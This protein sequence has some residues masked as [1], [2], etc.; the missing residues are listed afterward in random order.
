[1]RRNINSTYTNLTIIA[2]IS[3]CISIFC[4]CSESKRNTESFVFSVMGD[5]PRSET[6]K[7]ILQEQ[8]RKHNKQSKSQ[9]V[10]HVGDIKSGQ[11]YCD[12]E[13]YKIVADYLKQFKVPVFI[14]PG[15]NEWNDCKNPNQAWDF[16]IKYFSRFDQ[17]WDVPFVVLRQ[18]NYPVNI[19]FVKNNILFIAINLVGG[20]IH[21]KVEWDIMQQN[22]VDWIED[23]TVNNNVNAAVILAQA[24]F[25]EKHKIF[26]GQ[27][28]KLVENFKKPIMF[29]HGDGHVWLHDDPWMLPNMIH[30]QVDKGGIADPL[31]VTVTGNNKINFEFNRNPF[32]EK[33]I[34]IN[35]R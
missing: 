4:S 10:F 3:I 8:I 19:S 27:F 17:N 35:N 33:D 5:V 9:F 1:M 23:Q 30:V 7:T 11:S 34:L 26:A 18:N 6:E 25:D 24:N 13:N 12:E 32:R 21:N 15:D 28:L 14:V 20:R 16:W 2:I 29:I 22:A 31:E